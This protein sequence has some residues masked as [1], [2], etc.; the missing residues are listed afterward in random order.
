MLSLFCYVYCPSS[1]THEPCVKATPDTVLQSC[2]YLLEQAGCSSTNCNSVCAPI[3][4]V[5]FIPEVCHNSVDFHS[6]KCRPHKLSNKSLL[7]PKYYNTR[8]PFK[9]LISFKLTGNVSC[10]WFY[11]EEFMCCQKSVWAPWNSLF[12]LFTQWCACV[13]STKSWAYT[14]NAEHIDFHPLVDNDEDKNIISMKRW[15]V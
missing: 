1:I 10:R 11:Y 3:H 15:D 5:L 14:V 4:G 2:M 8:Y 12:Y 7:W 6:S 9:Y 13:T